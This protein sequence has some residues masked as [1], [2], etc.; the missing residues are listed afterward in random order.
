[1]MKS[2]IAVL[3][4]HYNNPE[5]LKA[6]LSSIREQT[7]VDVC[8]VD[9][10]SVRK[11]DWEQLTKTYQAGT[12]HI[13]ELPENQGIEHALNYGLAFIVNAGYPYVGRLDC[14]DVCHPNR[15]AKQLDYLSEHTE[16]ALLGTWVNHVSPDGQVLFTLKHPSQ[17]GQIKKR[18][19]LNSMFVHPSVVFRSSIVAKVG[20]Y[21]TAYKAAEDYAYFFKVVRNYRAE[22]LEEVLLDYVVEPGSISSSKRRTQVLSRIRIILNNFYPG[23]YPVYGLLRNIGLLFLSRN[24]TTAIKRILGRTED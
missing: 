8:V 7:P 6:S 19:Y 18:M 3:I 23:L 10:G 9:D 14:G 4:P 12:L 11:P 16:V 20:D 17:Y 21:P 1:M 5:G 24:A 15:F 22:N 2:E 13:L